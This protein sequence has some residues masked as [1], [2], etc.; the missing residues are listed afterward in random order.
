MKRNQEQ[1]FGLSC[2]YFCAGSTTL[3]WRITKPRDPFSVER[4]KAFVDYRRVQDSLAVLAAGGTNPEAITRGH[5]QFQELLEVMHENCV[6]RLYTAGI[7][8]DQAEIISALH[9]PNFM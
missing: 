7:T 9:T 4:S 5:R 2:S 6:K 3:P 8:F 1:P